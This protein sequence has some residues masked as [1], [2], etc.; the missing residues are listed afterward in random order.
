MLSYL[1]VERIPL[2]A[3]I[4]PLKQ[5]L[6]HAFELFAAV[7]ETRCRD[8]STKTRIETLRDQKIQKVDAKLQR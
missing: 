7:N 3:E 4:N 6:K 5:G 2:V 8:K 1:F